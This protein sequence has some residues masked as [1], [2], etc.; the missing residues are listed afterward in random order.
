MPSKTFPSSCAIGAASMTVRRGR[1]RNFGRGIG[2]VS[3]AER[4]TR[5]RRHFNSTR[6]KRSAAAVNAQVS[7]RPFD[8]PPIPAMTATKIDGTAI[9]KSIRERISKDVAEKT[10]QEFPLQAFTGHN[11]G[12]R[13]F[14]QLHLCAHETQGRGRSEYSLQARALRPIHLR[15]RIAAQDRP[16]QQR[17][18]CAWNIGATATTPSNQRV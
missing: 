16:I 2:V 14:G 17:S 3:G 4:T 8:P 15:I 9:A 5:T 13:P 1:S 11:S 18:E 12:W 10:I 7:S 6:I